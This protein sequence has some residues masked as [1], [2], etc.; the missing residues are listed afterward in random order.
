[1]PGFTNVIDAAIPPEEAERWAFVIPDGDP[2]GTGLNAMISAGLHPLEETGFV[3]L[4]RV[5]VLD[6]SSVAAIS[7]T[8]LGPDSLDVADHWHLLVGSDHVISRATAEGRLYVCRASADSTLAGSPVE[9]ALPIVAPRGTYGAPSTAAFINADWS[10]NDHALLLARRG[11]VQVVLGNTAGDSLRFVHLDSGLVCRSTT[12]RAG[13]LGSAAD[14]VKNTASARRLGGGR[15]LSQVVVVAPTS[16]GYDQA[17]DLRVLD[18]EP[19]LRAWAEL[20]RIAGGD[21]H[22]LQLGTVCFLPGDYR[23]V[24]YKRLDTTWRPE[25]GLDDGGDIVRTL[26]DASWVELGTEVLRAGVA[27]GGIVGNRPHTIRYDESGA[28]YVITTWDEWTLGS[29]RVGPTPAGC[30]YRVDAWVP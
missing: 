11:G 15:E 17:G 14:R 21:Q 20:A 13:Q 4:G 5:N 19:D 10:T 3:R 16:L 22:Q 27:T 1:M 7:W 23:L 18:A 8:T 9:A 2:A 28:V 6:A 12:L 25:P 30:R 24:T 29:T 26:F